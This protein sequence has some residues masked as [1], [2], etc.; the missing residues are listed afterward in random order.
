M[1]STTWA[2]RYDVID[3]WSLLLAELYVHLPVKR[4][5]YGYDVVRALEALRRE[6]PL[7]TDAEFHRG[8]SITINRLRDAH[9]QHVNTSVDPGLVA[10]L[11]FL[12]ESFG[13]IPHPDSW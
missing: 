2:Q 9:T 11:P 1:P 4:S 3:T 8:L 12:V 7:L 5:L 10:R 13:P 6:V